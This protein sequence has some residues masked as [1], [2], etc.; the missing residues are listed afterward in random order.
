[1]HMIMHDKKAFAVGSRKCFQP[2]NSKTGE[3]IFP[4]TLNFALF[5]YFFLPQLMGNKNSPHYWLI[6]RLSS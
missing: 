4:L 2:A 1:M 6:S 3:K 5:R